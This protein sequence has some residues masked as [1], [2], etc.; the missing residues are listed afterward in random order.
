MAGAGAALAGTADGVFY[1]PAG[2]TFLKSTEASVEV[3]RLPW[4]LPTGYWS[5][6][7]VMPLL[8]SRNV[9]VFPSGDHMPLGDEQSV[10][11]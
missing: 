4:M 6:A 11:E 1:N 8:P 5:A 7:C 2:P 9:G 3:C 10:C